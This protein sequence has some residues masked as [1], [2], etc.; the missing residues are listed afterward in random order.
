MEDIMAHRF[1]AFHGVLPIANLADALSDRDARLLLDIGLVRGE[2][3]SLR[4]AED[5]SQTV[6]PPSRRHVQWRVVARLFE[7]V[8][9]RRPAPEN[10]QL[11]CHKF[12]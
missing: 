1:P 11:R 2:D 7:W 4:L 12:P 5:P 9:I 8:A 10:L 6:S 3:G